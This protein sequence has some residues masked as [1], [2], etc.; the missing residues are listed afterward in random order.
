MG[1]TD[2]AKRAKMLLSAGVD[3]FGGLNTVQPIVTAY[4]DPAL[5]PDAII[6]NFESQNAAVLDVML[7]S[8]Q[9]GNDSAAPVA[10]KPT[11]ML[12]MQFPKDMNEVETQYEDVP[13]DM[14]CYIDTE[15]NVYD[16]GFGLTYGAPDGQS[17]GATVV[18]D[19]SVNP[20]YQ[21]YVTENQTPMT[22]PLNQGNTSSPYNIANR[23]QVKFDYGYKEAGADKANKYLIKVVNAGETVTFPPEPAR[24]DYKFAGWYA[25]QS[26]GTADQKADENAAITANA[27]YYA[28]WLGEVVPPPG[29]GGDDNPGGG[30]VNPGG[31][32]GRT[33]IDPPVPATEI[34]EIDTP[35]GPAD[36]DMLVTAP[37]SQ[38]PI[39]V[40][41]SS[42]STGYI[43]GYPDN[44]VRPDNNITRYEVASM[45]YKLVTNEDKAEYAGAVSVF[46]DVADDQW[47]SEAVGFLTA[48]GVLNGYEDGTFRG[49]NPITRAE[50][51][52]IVT[53]FGE[54][55]PEGDMPFSDVPDDH[56]AYNY[57]LSAYNNGW[58]QGYP[59]GTFGVDNFI[60]RA[61]AITIVNNLLGWDAASADVEL[62][63]FTDLTGEE[64]YYND[65][66][67]AANG[68]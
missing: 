53:K 23:R 15:G 66:L 50:F 48:A 65:I 13:R 54:M 40:L 38:K 29:G 14:V 1:Y 49:D 28:V 57:I 22:A 27:V 21:T 26:P 24:A 19:A 16:F 42:G 61:E 63:P 17:A 6:C 45:F 34:T 35:E 3:Q 58:I 5:T 43:Q 7:G 44:T 8:T 11:A 41:D 56:W 33:A 10:I 51:V 46:S 47:F 4:N 20:G 64:W 39:P 18:I 52:K 9:Y 30:N 59:D 25:V 68:L 12:P 31:G 62:S 36:G 2:M 32:G 37:V 67:L 60:I 55:N